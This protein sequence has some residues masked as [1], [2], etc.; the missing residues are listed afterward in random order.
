[1]MR[2]LGICLVVLAAL[3][4]G[5]LFG[6]WAGTVW[7]GDARWG[8]TALVLFVAMLGTGFAGGITVSFSE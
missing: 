3:M 8:E 7:T 5:A 4:F 2:A 1:M 6:C